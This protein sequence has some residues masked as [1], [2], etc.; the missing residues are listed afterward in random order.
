MQWVP[1]DLSLGIK[2]P[3]RE[4][5]HSPLSSAEVK[6][7]WSYT[8]TPPIR[9]HGVAP[10]SFTSVLCIVSEPP[11]HHRYVLEMVQSALIYTVFFSNI[12]LRRTV[13]TLNVCCSFSEYIKT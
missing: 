2:G 11:F 7:A 10:L 1:R 8:S 6:N 12:G 13:R 4:A 9:L 5:D 3:G